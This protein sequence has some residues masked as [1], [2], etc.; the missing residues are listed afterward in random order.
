M[1]KTGHPIPK[2]PRAASEEVR[3][4]IR[5]GH[6]AQVVIFCDRCGDVE[7]RADYTGGTRKVRFAAARRHLVESEGWHCDDQVDVCPECLKAVAEE[8]TADA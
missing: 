3:A 2:N 6:V 5:A 8:M 1:S 7:H 4:A